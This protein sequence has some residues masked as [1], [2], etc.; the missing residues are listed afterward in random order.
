MKKDKILEVYE[1]TILN[2]QVNPKDPSGE[3][4]GFV[5]MVANRVATLVD[6]G[7]L[8]RS[9]ARKIS[10]FVRKTIKF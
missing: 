10:D 2:E 3:R 7:V 5:Q 4:E 9:E 6:Y 8:D 1:E